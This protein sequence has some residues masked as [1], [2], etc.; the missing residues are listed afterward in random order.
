VCKAVGTL[1]SKTRSGSVFEFDWSGGVKFV[2]VSSAYPE[3]EKP[4]REAS[5][6]FINP[7]YDNGASASEFDGFGVI[8]NKGPG[9]P[10]YRAHLTPVNWLKEVTLGRL[11]MKSGFEP[12][13]VS[14]SPEARK[15]PG[16]EVQINSALLSGLNQEGYLI[17]YHAFSMC[18]IAVIPKHSDG[19]EVGIGLVM[20]DGGQFLGS[21]AVML[22]VPGSQERALFAPSDHINGLNIT[23]PKSGKLSVVFLGKDG[24][25]T[26]AK[27]VDWA[28]CAL[29]D[30][31]IVLQ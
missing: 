30:R 8:L 21:H 7:L 1:A 9:Y 24:V 29:S 10:A 26:R 19:A 22:G 2:D 15:R 4:G 17:K 23:R 20:A 14:I 18:T 31:V 12:V 28:E 3:F 27:T 13:R 5:E 16:D 25:P 6:A 11:S